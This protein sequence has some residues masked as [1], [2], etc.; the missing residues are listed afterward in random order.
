MLDPK[1][2][3]FQPSGQISSNFSLEFL[4]SAFLR[5]ASIVLRMLLLSL[6]NNFSNFPLNSSRVGQ[7]LFPKHID[8]IAHFKLRPLFLCQ[9]Q[10][11]FQMTLLHLLGPLSFCNFL[12]LFF[13]QHQRGR[14][15]FD[16]FIIYA[17]RML[18][19]SVDA[20]LAYF[21]R[22]VQQRDIPPFNIW[23]PVQWFEAP[24]KQPE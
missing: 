13:G 22:L 17:N 19:K 23:D 8:P 9:T 10:L 18:N 12:D 11:L 6:F 14:L 15:M 24:P 21:S 16:Q 4:M 5:E 2:R 3:S 20:I 7:S 1:Y